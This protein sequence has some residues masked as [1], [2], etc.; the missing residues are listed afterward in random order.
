MVEAI[1]INSF[2]EIEKSWD[3]LY[4][5]NSQLT[6][7]QSTEYM[8]ELWN[9][10]LPYRFILRITPKFYVFKRD[11]RVIMILPLFK[12][13]FRN[14]YSLYGF[15]AGAG[16]LD[17]IYAESITLKDITECFEALKNNT[18]RAMIHFEH[19]KDKTEFGRWIIENGGTVSTEGCTEIP[20][21]DEYEDYHSSLS[22][23]MK[24]NI[25][26]A[27]N[28]L[29]TDEKVYEYESIAYAEISENISK[30]LQQLYIDRQVSKYGKNVL[31]RFFVNHVD[32]GTKIHKSN[33][34]KVMASILSQL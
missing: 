5:Q 26:T 9:N 6:Y 4:S 22:K 11:K 14:C 18:K 12:K 32:L 13:W 2:F 30:K 34:V 10:L 25:R 33:D 3:E 1:E 15:K 31:Y 7:Y 27:Y 20:L 21:P 23:H 8:R 24:Q 29:K 17:A 16:Y 19:V 28:R